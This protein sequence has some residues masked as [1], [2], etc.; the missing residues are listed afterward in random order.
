[1]NEQLMRKISEALDSD[2]GLTGD[3]ELAK[4]LMEDSEASAYAKQLS[5]LQR[6]VTAWPLETPSEDEFEALALRIDAELG[7]KFSG[8]F[9]RAPDFEED[10]DLATATSALMGAG[11]VQISDSGVEPL[12]ELSGALEL[13]VS[14]ITELADQVNDEVTRAPEPPKLRIAPPAAALL[15][16][17]AAPKAKPVVAAVKGALPKVPRPGAAA[18]VVAGPV[19]AAP[20]VAAPV[21]TAPAVPLSTAVAEAAP[22]AGAVSVAVTPAAVVQS[23]Q[24]AEIEVDLDVAESPV[25]LDAPKAP[26]AAPKAPPNVPKATATAAAPPTP[27]KAPAASKAPAKPKSPEREDRI[28][29]PVPAAQGPRLELL[30]GGARPAKAT[31]QEAKGRGWLPALLAAAAIGIG[32]IGVGTLTM[33][34]GSS[35]PDR[36]A[37]SATLAPSAGAAAEAPS[38]MAAAPSVMEP[39]SASGGAPLDQAPVTA[40]PAPVMPTPPPAAIAAAD[41]APAEPAAAEPATE[42]QREEGGALEVARSSQADDARRRAVPTRAGRS[43]AAAGGG[44]GEGDALGGAERRSAEVSAAPA[45]TAASSGRAASAGASRPAPRAAAAPVGETLD[46]ATV[47]SVMQGVEPAVRACAGERHGTALVDVVVQ[48]SGRVSAA[49]VTGNFQGS[50]EGSCIAR[51]VR[52]A[53]FPGFTGEPL[54]FRYP[55]GI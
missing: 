10:E 54:R 32:V 38:E 37:A 44:G 9:T 52:G 42:R 45:A 55:F 20:V 22:A 51:A 43:G 33:N 7:Q 49:T 15:D 39:E 34:G 21:G 13:T 19:G 8:D 40:A 47:Q 50:V 24:S 14:A 53:Q 30:E 11:A 5:R 16:L 6:W 23:A 1:M 26:P 18:P 28:S 17:P 25:S 27:P 35:A 2:D 46:R 48:G 29:I 12:V 3:P 31:P 36:G 41:L 4:I